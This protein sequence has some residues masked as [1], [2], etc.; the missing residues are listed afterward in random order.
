M[1]CNDS[2][3]KVKYKLGVISDVKVSKD[4]AVRSATV[5]YCNIR[6]NAKGEDLVTHMYVKRSVQ[7]LALILPIEEASSSVVVNDY[8]HSVVCTTE[9]SGGVA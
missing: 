8:E 1:I 2:K 3:V 6:K 7:R 9:T 5:R 4:G